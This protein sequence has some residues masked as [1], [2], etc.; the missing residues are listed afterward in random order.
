ML[1]IFS[2]CYLECCKFNGGY[3]LDGDPFHRLCV[4]NQP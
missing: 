2:R 3:Q 1:K 4:H